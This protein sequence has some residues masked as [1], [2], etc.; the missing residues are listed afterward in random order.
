MISPVFVGRTDEL[1]ALRGTLTAPGSVG[2]P[3]VLV[4]GEA[5]IGKSRLLAELIASVEADPPGR[6]AV[7]VATGACV[8]FAAGELPYA[9]VIELLEHIA[10]VA[11]GQVTA[12]AIS[13]AAE[14][15]GAV[16]AADTRRASADRSP[17]AAGA[18]RIRH[19]VRLHALIVAL[20]STVDVVVAVDDLH[21]ADR[22][23][24]DA[25]AF[26]ARRL[27]GMPVTLVL[28]YRSD[29]LHRR[30]P[31][32]PWLGEIQRRATRMRLELR[33]LADVAVAEQVASIVG[34]GAADGVTGSVAEMTGAVVARADGNPFLVEE[35]VALGR[36]AG[37]PDT[38]R[39]VLLARLQGL[40]SVARRA[41]ATAAV[42]GREMDRDLLET[43]ADLPPETL[44]LAL[45]A[46]VDARILQ[47]APGPTRVAS[48]RERYRFRH[49]LL[50]EAVADDLL[51]TERR[52]LHR[53][54]AEALAARGETSSAGDAA[55]IAHHW[56]EAHDAGRAFTAYL[57]AARAAE[58]A[59]GWSEA[60]VAYDRAL[61]LWDEAGPLAAAGTAR[62]DI[63]WHAG[64]AMAVSGQPTRGLATLLEA[65]AEA[66]AASDDER[67]AAACLQAAYVASDLG[68]GMTTDLMEQASR[69]I[70]PGPSP[71]RA[72]ILGYDAAFLAITERYREAIGRAREAIAVAQAVDE[73]DGLVLAF[74]ALE[75]ASHY[76]GLP[77]DG[78]AA[79]DAA[80]A[81]AARSADPS[82][83][84]TVYANHAQALFVAGRPE[85][86]IGSIA[87]ALDTAH[88][89]GTEGSA[90]P[91]FEPQGAE[92]LWWLGRWDEAE[93]R[94]DRAAS[95]RPEGKPSSLAQLVIARLAAWRGDGATAGS[96]LDE[97]A[98]RAATSFDPWDRASV[99]VIRAEH[100][101]SQG[102]H[103]AAL[104]AAA[105]GLAELAGR[106]EL[107]TRALLLAL[108]VGACADGL[109][110]ARAR[111]TDPVGFDVDQHLALVEDIRDGRLVP[112]A[113]PPAFAETFLALADAERARA[114]GRADPVTWQLSVDA[115]DRAG[116]V[117]Y[118]AY[119]RYRLAEALVIA[120]DRTAATIVLVAARRTAAELRA[121]PLLGLID[122]L[123]RRARL[124][125]DRAARTASAAETAPPGTPGSPASSA[126]PGGEAATDPWGLS[127]REREVL[128]LVASGWTNRRIG[129]ALFITEKTAS[130]HVTHILDKLGVS[131]RTEA[132]LMAGRA[133]ILPA[134]PPDD[135]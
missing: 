2:G 123:A 81:A 51:P 69:L 87:E 66:E 53:R 108:A 129:D 58:T 74:S 61:E 118:G 85:Q 119:A 4:T 72:R 35:L 120:G 10:G 64:R 31:L 45:H 23:T 112:G 29:E 122:D 117:P 37:L 106:D 13:L 88:A 40:E 56:A 21:W 6:R 8:E 126:V 32:P 89:F 34:P 20:A 92:M 7:L 41:L 71:Q 94:L 110:A 22:S 132:A 24:L 25:L 100:A 79:F 97:A 114:A 26:L 52:R 75:L 33:P 65:I 84:A 48:G 3:V 50:R 116:L 131:T 27:E 30:H 47:V 16:E 103:L 102:D 125:L 127:A 130:V 1:E 12:E 91:W 93:T 73:P 96:A 78:D 54:V 5:G 14:L 90:E 134:A 42:V 82:A 135:S 11:D 19:F 55:E 60:T 59:G 43:V 111:R 57:T 121:G 128:E 109:E 17:A 83:F 39:E 67:V 70:P 86:A 98:E 95:W 124:D 44:D 77:E 36:P 80:R 76:L 46:A 105:A 63:L 68:D 101:R 38:L 18:A 115:L 99:E 107:P 49:A 9:P 62:A 113:R 133:G 104:A 15:A 28:L